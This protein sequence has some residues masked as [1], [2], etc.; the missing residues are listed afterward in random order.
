MVLS[1][2]TYTVT[3]T[4][5]NGCTDSNS[6]ILMEPAVLNAAASVTSTLACHG[7]TNGQ[8]T[9]SGTGGTPSYLYAWSNGATSQ[10]A[11]SLSAGTYTVTITD[12]NGCTDSNSTI[13]TEPSPLN[14]VTSVTSPL[15]CNGDTDGQITATGTG[16]TPSY[17]YA[18]SNGATTATASGLSAGTYTVTV[19]DNNGC[20]ASNST[21]LMEPTVLIAASSVTSTLACNGNT[22]G[23]ITAS[24][25]G[26]TPSYIFAWSNGATTATASGLSAG[27]YTVTVTDQNGCTD[28]NST[29]LMEPAVLNAAASVTSTLACNGDTNG[30]ITASGTG[31]TPS[32]LYAWSNGATSQTASSLSAGTYT[33][34][35]TDAN[36]C[37]DSNSTILTEPSALNVV[38]SVTS[39]LDCNGDTDGQITATASGGTGTIIYVWS[40]GSTD[41]II[42]DLSAGTYT[43]TVTDNNGCTASTSETINDQD[44]IAITFEDIINADCQ[45][46]E[47]GSA[48]ASATGGV[49]GYTYLW[50]QMEIIQQQLWELHAGGYSVTVTDENGCT[51][52]AAVLNY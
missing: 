26:G 40:N 18:W 46:N 23:Q 47:T 32:Y 7:D 3:V 50:S 2:G 39:P 25:S 8:I 1:A 37:T 28:S 22:D 36:G 27:T 30:Q 9:A 10:T 29:I 24:A 43:V 31:G 42:S 6:T 51:A 52:Q 35:I 15:D 11:S 21:I 14:V 16:G 41:P 4:D 5:Q 19:T 13:L 17:L 12:A 48:T 34:T 44:L 20:T 49:G 45:G 33:V 38:T